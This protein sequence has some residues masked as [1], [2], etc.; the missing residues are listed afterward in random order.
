MQD[1]G[2]WGIDL[3][4]PQS[5]LLALHLRDAAGLAPPTSPVLPDLPP[6]D[7]PVRRL[8]VEAGLEAASRQWADWWVERF[9]GGADALTSILPPR[10]PGL[11]GRTELRGIAELGMDDAVAWC[12]RVRE[13]EKRVIARSPSA[14]FETNLVSGVE[15]ELGWRIRPFDLR[16]LVLPVA[17]A[18]AWDVVG[19]PVISLGLRADR[20]AYL[21]WL[22][23]QL[24]AIGRLRIAR[25]EGQNT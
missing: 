5:L 9:P 15:R 2:A 4:M 24:V 10:Y 13:I 11:R 6:L 21:A 19:Q 25:S 23:E 3:T 16:I 17:G 18:H 12:A 20:D 14:L 7:P 22:R 8:H 1:V